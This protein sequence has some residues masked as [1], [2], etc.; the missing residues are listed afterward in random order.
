VGAIPTVVGHETTQRYA[1]PQAAVDWQCP[2]LD[3]LTRPRRQHHDTLGRFRNA[4]DD[5]GASSEAAAEEQQRRKADRA[6]RTSAL[7]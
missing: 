7:S 4:L 6:A 1:E 5:A 2:V 3:L